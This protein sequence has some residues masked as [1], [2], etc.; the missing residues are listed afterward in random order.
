MRE[1]VLI[2]LGPRGVYSLVA[3]AGIPVDARDQAIRSSVESRHLAGYS[4][5][6]IGEWFPTKAPVSFYDATM[7]AS[8]QLAIEYDAAFGFPM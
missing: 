8:E 2:L 7:L 3:L 1:S 6:G 4:A 5:N